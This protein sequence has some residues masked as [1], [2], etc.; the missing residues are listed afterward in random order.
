[1]TFES[2]KFCWLSASQT[3]L[4]PNT[5]VIFSPNDVRA[6]DIFIDGFALQQHVKFHAASSATFAWS[7]FFSLR[8]LLHFNH[9]SLTN[10]FTSTSSSSNQISKNNDIISMLLAIGNCFHINLQSSVISES[11]IERSH[12]SHHCNHRWQSSLY[13]R[14]LKSET[15]NKRTSTSFCWGS[16]FFISSSWICF[17]TQIDE[18]HKKANAKQYLSKLFGLLSN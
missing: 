13:Q 14:L 6:P 15:I 7:S 12:W 11:S 8:L 5:L 17:D 4:V 1:M 2:F 16:S 9:S 10:S 3:R 18:P